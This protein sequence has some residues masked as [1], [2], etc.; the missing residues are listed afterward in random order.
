MKLNLH[1]FINK[2]RGRGSNPLSNNDVTESDRPLVVRETGCE[3]GT[4]LPSSSIAVEIEGATPSSSEHDGK[5]RVDFASAVDTVRTTEH[6]PSVARPR[7]SISTLQSSRCP[8]RHGTVYTDPYP[9]YIHG[10]IHDIQV[11]MPF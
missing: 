8:F 10:M 7:P 4:T 1:K 6:R 9:G 5:A 3:V 2:I 11:V